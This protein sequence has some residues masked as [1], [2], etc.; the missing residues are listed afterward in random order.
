MTRKTG[1]KSIL[2][3]ENVIHFIIMCPYV[4][5]VYFWGEGEQEEIFFTYFGPKNSLEQ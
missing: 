1:H 2:I 5:F 3:K 4:Q